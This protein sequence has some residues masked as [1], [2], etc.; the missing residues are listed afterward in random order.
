MKLLIAGD[1]FAAQWPNAT[2]GWVNL[3][4]EKYNVVNIAQPGIGEYKILKQIESQDVNSFDLVIVSHTSPSRLHTKNHPIH[5]EGFHKD[6]DLI[7]N[8][9]IDRSSLGNASLKAAQEY[10][11]YHYDDTYQ[12]DIYN[13]IRKQIN[14]LISAPYVSISHVDI[15]NE[16]AIETNHIDFSHLWSKERGTVNHYTE[17]GNREIFKKLEEIIGE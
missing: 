7:L 3:L 12:I 14:S 9:L 2:T 10:F 1:S 4:A 17:E 11:K 16:L 8:D 13:L 6:C 5:N 15:A